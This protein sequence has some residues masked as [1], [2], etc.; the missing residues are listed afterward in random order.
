LGSMIQSAEVRP[1]SLGWYTDP[2]LVLATGSSAVLLLEAS[3]GADVVLAPATIPVCQA[4]V[5]AIAFLLAWREQQRLKLSFLLGLALMFQVGWISVHLA[6]GVVS[7]GDTERYSELGHSLLS[8]HYPAAE[9]PAGAVLLFAFEALWGGSSAV[10]VFH[11]FA[12]IPFQL[13]SAAAVWHLRTRWSGW[14]AA[15]VAVWPLNAF[16]LELKYDAV[17]TAA[18]AIGLLLALRGRWYLSAASL[19]LGAALKWT[20]GLAGLS[21]GI[22]LLARGERRSAAGY[23]ATLAG[24]F[25]FVHVPFLALAPTQ[26]LDAY[27]Q[28]G[29]RGITAESV[30]YIPLRVFGLARFGGEVWAEA[31]VPG[32]AG[33]TAV[34]LQ[35]LVVVILG[36]AAV[37]VR[38]DLEAAVAIAAMTPAAFLLLNRV[39]SPQFFVLLVAVWCIGA[40]LLAR[41]PVEQLLFGGLIMCGTLANV[42]VY[43]V[44]APAWGAFSAL[45]FASGLAVTAW[46]VVAALRRAASVSRGGELAVKQQ[47][48]P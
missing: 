44:I 11:A 6:N 17:P 42:L 48:A 47:V 23:V 43:P 24:T 7:D 39:F 19:G 18:L 28:Q 33:T 37:Q 40:S 30:F 22:W 13:L 2:H 38:R 46:I 35:A 26:V 34:G 9:Y 20:P 10:R 8:G 36:I 4:L 5:A 45:A 21:L 14:L 32:W 15:I 1:R 31:I 12:M 27:E 3:R 29:S 25:L 16:Y 41:S